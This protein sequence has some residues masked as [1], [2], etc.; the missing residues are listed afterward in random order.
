MSSPL[1]SN[2]RLKRECSVRERNIAGCQLTA[3]TDLLSPTPDFISQ[4][5]LLALSTKLKVFLEGTICICYNLLSTLT[6][7]HQVIHN[8]VVK[9]KAGES[10]PEGDTFSRKG[11]SFPTYSSTKPHSF[12]CTGRE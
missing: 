9:Y 3:S 4:L 1:C 10:E 11:F 6:V 2:F 5:K 8:A 12:V 7:Y